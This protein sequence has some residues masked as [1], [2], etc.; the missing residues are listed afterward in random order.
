MTREE[1]LRECVREAD[2]KRLERMRHVREALYRLPQERAES[3][4]LAPLVDTRE[5]MEQVA[6]CWRGLP[7]VTSH[8]I[9]HALRCASKGGL[10]C[11]CDGRGNLVDAR[12]EMGS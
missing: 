8:V 3:E 10:L 11:N 7:D 6:E 12:E 5:E 9:G 2:S 4:S 1:Y